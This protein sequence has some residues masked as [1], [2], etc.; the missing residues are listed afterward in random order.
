MQVGIPK[1][2]KTHECRVGAAPD[3]AR[4]L[5]SLVE[6]NPGA[7]T[8]LSGARYLATGAELA[9]KPPEV[10]AALLRDN[11]SLRLQV[12]LNSMDLLIS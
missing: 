3:G 8:G 2:I 12:D 11:R 4:E 9:Y 1:E 5:V 7:A 6:R 10:D